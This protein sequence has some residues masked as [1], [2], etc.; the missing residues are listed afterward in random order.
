MIT[1]S[2]LDSFAGSR[3]VITGV[4]GTVGRE[5]LRQVL[6]A[7]PASVLGLDHN[8]TELFFTSRRYGHMPHTTFRL[9]DVRD[10]PGISRHLVDVDV[11]LHAA[12]LKHVPVC[13]DSPREAI[14]T[15]IEGTQNV[16]DAAVRNGVPRV[17]FTSSDK[18]VNPTSVMGTSK[19]MA[20]RLV[21]AADQ[22]SHGTTAASTRFGNVL[23]SRG[24]V[25]PVFDEQIRLG[26]PVTITNLGMSRFIMTLPEAVN[27][28]LKSTYLGSGGEVFITKMP[29]ARVEDL[30]SIMIAELAPLYGHE[31]GSVEIDVTGTRPGEKLYEELVSEEEVRRTFDIG[32]FLV[33]E[34][35]LRA[36]IPTPN[37]SRIDQPYN[38]AV[39][40]PLS[41][42]ELRDY[43]KRNELLLP[44]DRS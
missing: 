1:P 30:A 5:L 16:L 24:S 15:N 37:G 35:A 2:S 40:T 26:G 27:L 19:L 42:E 11:I 18:A 7:A 8:E 41:P 31:P 9:V 17:L 36:E 39:E 43:M 33:V 12:A 13:E 29:V 21:T 28:V 6:E 38:S 20:E 25:L 44:G 3:V 14:L 22:R 4:C 32:D 10:R 23:G 34:P